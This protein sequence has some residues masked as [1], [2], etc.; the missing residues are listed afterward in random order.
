MNDVTYLLLIMLSS[1]GDNFHLEIEKL[2]QVN[3][4]GLKELLKNVDKG[5]I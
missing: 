4:T 3:N 5:K 1:Y 2:W